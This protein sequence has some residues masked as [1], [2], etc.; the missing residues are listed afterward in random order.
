MGFFKTNNEY[1]G[2][3][4][5][6]EDNLK[7]MIGGASSLNIGASHKVGEGHY[8]EEETP[9]GI[10]IPD[11]TFMFYNADS[12]LENKLP[13]YLKNNIDVLAKFKG[14]NFYLNM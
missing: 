4:L 13:N 5:L 12:T 9:N 2:H 14:F 6:K 10:F 7:L 3:D 11:G 1:T 8:I